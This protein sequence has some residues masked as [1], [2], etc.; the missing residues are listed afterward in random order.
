[1]QNFDMKCLLRNQKFVLP[2]VCCCESVISDDLCY[3]KCVRGR[4]QIHD[5]AKRSKF[6]DL[7]FEA[8]CNWYVNECVGCWCL[9]YH[10]GTK[11]YL[12]SEYHLCN[13]Y[14]CY[15]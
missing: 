9:L 4:L 13:M 6:C 15:N 7:M 11:N 8:I 12:H 10:H 5:Q 3:T 2:Y 14:I 1:M